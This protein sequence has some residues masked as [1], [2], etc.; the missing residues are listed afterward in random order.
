M[1]AVT[2]YRP[3]IQL[4]SITRSIETPQGTKC[5]TYQQGTPDFDNYLSESSE[6]REKMKHLKSVEGDSEH[7]PKNFLAFGVEGKTGNS[8]DRTRQMTK[9][10]N[11]YHS[12]EV[13]AADVKDTLSAIIA[14]LRETYTEMG[15]DP[16]EFTPQL[17]RNVYDT[18]RL[19]NICG[20]F[21]AG[22]YDSCPLAAK[23]NGHDGNT[24]DWIYY[25]AKYYHSSE[26][27][28][29]ELQD[30]IQEIGEAYGVSDL[31]LPITYPKGDLRETIYTSYN[32]FINYKAREQLYIG[33]M[34]DENMVPPKDFRFF[35]KGNTSGTNIYPDSL[36]PDGLGSDIFDGVLHV[37]YGDWS[38]T[39]RVPVGGSVSDPLCINMYDLIRSKTDRIPGEITSVLKNFDCHS[40]VQSWRYTSSH[41][42][43]LPQ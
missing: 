12:G 20:A 35:Y 21:T 16:A 8:L 43:Q 34:I 5:V 14:D 15:F 31:E 10:F 1:K 7:V 17:L 33:N 6:L 37:W 32:T 13:S 27:M 26:T 29:G 30:M 36:P 40:M 2:T 25:D 42:R 38:F 3:T 23:Y 24:K 39:G 28:K 4:Q 22:W 18:A 19:D 11:Q 41:P 9:I